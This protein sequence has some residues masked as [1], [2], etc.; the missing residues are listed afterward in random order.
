M[1]QRLL[2]LFTS[3][4]LFNSVH[5][6]DFR[7]TSKIL[8]RIVLIGDAGQMDK[9]G[10]HP[11][12]R[13]V[14][15][16]VPLGKNTTV[17]YLGDNLY[18]H[19]LPDEQ[20]AIYTGKRAVLDSQVLMGEL[21]EGMVYFIPG[22]H[23]WQNGGANGYKAIVRQ[24]R[25]VDN[26]GKKNVQ[27]Y[28]KDGCP[29][30]VSVKVG[31]DVVLIMMDTQWWLHPG[32]KPGIESD[33]SEKTKEEVLA[34]LEDI[35]QDNPTKLI[36]FA[37]HHP[38]KSKG[39]HGGYYTLKQHIFP[40]TDIKPNLYIPL[41]ILGTIYP[42][43]RA[44][45]GTPQDLKHPNYANMIDD[46]EEVL[47]GHP[48]VI[49]VAGHEHA[50]QW[51]ADST[52]NYIVTGSGCKTDRVSKSPET[53][54][55]YS[56]EGFA[57]LEVYEDKKVTCT[58][59]ATAPDSTK[60]LYTDLA[61]DFSKLPL[62][63]SFDTVTPLAVFKDT[64]IVPASTQYGTTTAVQRFLE[65]NNYRDV[66]TQPVNLKVFHMR[67][68]HGGMK[69]VKVGGGQQTKSLTLEDA[70]GKFWK[71]RTIDKDPEKAVPEFLRGTL[72]QKVVQDMISAGQPYA[73]LVVPTI[74]KVQGVAHS[75]PV[76]Y[77][78]PS[79][80]A[81]G[82]Y[83]EVF[84]NKVCMLEEADPS[85]DGTD[86]KS[87]PK[88]F[89]KLI[90]KGDHVVNQELVLKARL[91]DMVL[92]DWDR[93]F[94]QWKWGEYDT[95]K[96]KV[97][98]PIPVDRDQAM[99]LS[100]GLIIKIAS[101]R[102]LHW[103]KGFHD[104]LP[105]F[106]W[107]ARSARNF[108]RL[109]LNALDE[110]E[111]NELTDEFCEKLTDSVISEAV[112]QMPPE[113]YALR[114][115]EIERKLK[116]RRDLMKEKKAN[117]YYRFISK[118]VN[119]L[120]TNK[121]EFF[122]I[123]SV[124]SGLLV[125]VKS[126]D[127][128]EG[129]DTTFETYHRVF[130]PKVTKEIRLYG[131]NGA[132]NFM[133]DEAARSKIKLRI[134]G[135][136]GIDTFN[137]RGK[138]RTHLYDLDYEG[139]QLL[140]DKRVRNR[141]TD[142]PSVNEYQIENFD[143]TDVKFPWINLS[144]NG[145]DGVLAGLGYWRK[146]HGFRK[147]PFRAEHKLSSLFAPFRKAYQLKYEG[148]FTGIINNQ[149]D[150]LLFGQLKN[151]ALQN[152]FGFGNETKYDGRSL[153]NYRTRY[154]YFTAD[155]M[156]QNEIFS[157]VKIGVGPSY[158][159]YTY[160]K[161]DN[162]GRIVENPSLLGLDS[163]SI[164]NRKQ[165]LGGKA[166]FDINNLN[167]DLFPTRGINWRTTL[168]A[169][170]SLNDNSKPYTSLVSDMNVYAS[171]RDPA[172]LVAVLRLGGGHIFS[173]DYEYFQGMGIGQNNYLRGFRKTRFTGRSMAYGSIELRA[174][175]AEINSFI[176]PG[177]FGLVGFDDVG[178]VW[179][180]NENSK[181]WHNSIGGGIYFIPYNMILISATA[182]YSSEQVLFNLTFGTNLN[183]TF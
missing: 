108:D 32:D 123:K 24:Q 115:E 89:N 61:L 44:V 128:E 124:D 39:E 17:V 100:D 87:T 77:Y 144:Y 170:G 142:D 106:N 18:R 80:P 143:Y 22:N 72:A 122:T 117:Q 99:F 82:L 161:E 47:N 136:R 154:T 180:R 50:L 45:F 33:C 42:I 168:T 151:P 10:N 26:L 30:P 55:A 125:Q 8:E 152:F 86:V 107:L 56:N 65:G 156:L 155:A 53:K 3:F 76:F 81:F 179:E 169:Y 49:R 173:K 183:L 25:Y 92:G 12:E 43:T 7:D 178:R 75:T 98:Y 172:K 111:W 140:A 130:D 27:F 41:P 182:A 79:D 28:P 133:V 127:K 149:Y 90:E 16:Y 110:T 4:M 116:S 145:E 94:G 105:K 147:D 11:V 35:L 51:I 38:F 109:F 60:P 175:L 64:A 148:T 48:H 104:K 101:R 96:G 119:V 74:A 58:F 118:N 93:H 36:V 181:K 91:I 46:I 1:I 103:M 84:A 150:L 167:S 139:N 157:K 29:G 23:D 19:G 71:L 78:V 174:K 62:P 134:I 135:G 66:W 132:D 57:V 73:P 20:L 114:G 153:S 69:I 162:E 166:Y 164:F 14:Q 146:S 171:L 137:I 34:E 67:T 131:F 121:Q 52:N 59:Y 85:F 54:F 5:G 31:K 95:G 37:G 68:L 176:M 83:R 159:Y 63:R 9:H 15:R 113:I 112:H 102:P 88:I 163:N 70:S 177:A 120:G 13:A 160:D 158:Y 97:W 129:K 126:R 2:L 21:N 6:Q 141:M 165:Y 40:F 138:V